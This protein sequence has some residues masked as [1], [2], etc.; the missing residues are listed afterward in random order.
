M[1]ARDRDATSPHGARAR[2]L[3]VAGLG[4]RGDARAL[5]TEPPVGHGDAMPSDVPRLAAAPMS[6]AEGERELPLVINRHH[7]KK[8]PKPRPWIYIGRGSPLGNPFTV[9]EH[10]LDALELYR[11][12]LWRKLVERDPG[13]LAEMRKITAQ[14]H[15]VC[16]C[17]PRPC[18]GDVVVKAWAWLQTLTPDR[19]GQ[20]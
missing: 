2:A 18:H 7:Y 20:G 9:K 11:S 13:V 10:G 17:A 4:E 16:S 6:D 8:K 5:V 3:A 12:W 15:L 14:H 19:A 1:N